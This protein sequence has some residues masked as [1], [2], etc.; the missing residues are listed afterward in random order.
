[1]FFAKSL[2]GI[3]FH[4]LNVISPWQ[5]LSFWQ[6]LGCIHFDGMGWISQTIP[7]KIKLTEEERQLQIALTKRIMTG[8]SQRLRQTLILHDVVKYVSHW[9]KLNQRSSVHKLACHTLCTCNWGQVSFLLM[10]C[11]K[12]CIIQ[13]VD[14]STLCTQTSSLKDVGELF[15][16]CK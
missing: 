12:S 14:F 7:F 8:N 4:R 9:Y 1:M 6:T 10:S 15:M 13:Y 16:E 3:Y 11:W 5:A 2:A